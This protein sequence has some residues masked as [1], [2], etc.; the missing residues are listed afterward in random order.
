MERDFE[1]DDRATLNISEQSTIAPTAAGDARPGSAAR[2]IF[3]PA[4]LVAGRYRIVRFIAR[5]GMG[6]VYEAEDLDLRERVALKT[7]R[8][9]LV[10]E[11]RMVERFKREINLARKIAHPNVCRIFDL[12]RHP[13]AATA[14]GA[15][16]E[17]MFLTMEF[18]SGETLEARLRRAGRLSPVEALPLVRQMADALAA[19]HRAGV[20]HR[21]F[22]SANVMLVPP[23]SPDEETRVVITDFGLAQTGGG[24]SE[25]RLTS[26]TEPGW[27]VGTP[28]YIAP[29]QLEGKPTTAAADIYA[30]GVV[31]YEMTTGALPFD[32]DSPLAAALKRLHAAP[33]RP[34]THAPELAP[35]WEQV[36]LRCLEREPAERFQSATDVPRALDGDIMPAS[37]RSLE[38]QRLEVAAA[39]RRR[40]RH[41]AL[42]C[43]A[44]VALVACIAVGYNLRGA[45]WLRAATP[46]AQTPTQTQA[47]RSVALLGFKN[48]SGRADADW[49]SP[50]LSEM[51][52]TELAAGERL[53]IVPGENVARMKMELSLADADSLAADT[54]ARVRTNLGTDYVV[55]G[56]YTA[57]G[58]A[59]GW[60]VRLDL[61]LQNAATGELV[62]S[63][64]EAGGDAQLFDLI[65]RVGAR[66]RSALG[67]DALTPTEAS[68]LRASLPANA[69]A[70]RLYAE[71]R[72]RLNV[73][74]ALT[75][76]DLLAR[77]VVADPNYPLAHSALASAW[78]ALGYDERARAAAQRAYDLSGSLS[79]EERLAVE[80][81]Y[82][83]ALH[84]SD[85]AIEIYRTLFDFF[86]DTIEYGL[87]LVAVQARAG[88]AQAALATVARLRQ[89]PVPTADDPR[90]DMAESLV[91]DSLA[92]YKQEQATA[93]A[94]AIKGAQRGAWLVVAE[95]RYYEGWANWN[96]GRNEQALAAYE[97]AR[98][99][100]DAAGQRKGVADILNA[101]ASLRWGQ[102]DL[103]E[104]RRLYEE[105]L[106][107]K[108]EIGQQAGI[109]VILNNLGNVLK[110]EGDLTNARRNYEAALAAYREVGNKLQFPSTLLN[111]AEVL[112]GQGDLAGAQKMYEE[113]MTYSREFGRK[114]TLA[115]ALTELSD[116]L[117][118]RGDLP[119]A[120]KSCADG[121]AVARETGQKRGIA[122]GLHRLANLLRAQGDLTAAR[123][124]YEESL[125]LRN[126]LGEASNA[127]ESRLALAE[128]ALDENRPADAE[129]LA[130][131]AVETFT[132]QRAHE[133]EAAAT[134]VLARALAATGQTEA[135]RQAARQAAELP[136]TSEHLVDRLSV[137]IAVARAQAATGHAPEATQTLQSVLT[138]ATRL[139]FVSL[140][141]EAR[142]ALLEAK[143]Q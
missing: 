82:R 129:Q 42:V 125:A 121:L 79:R 100:Y 74:D 112:K 83:E 26:L 56:S 131:A 72:A 127:A 103:D 133:E 17:I 111:L 92:D 36:I 5:G 48:L 33:S 43:V 126:E 6:E 120:Q 95:A 21:D 106:A 105:A 16:R 114:N 10:A 107:I 135:A 75:A 110:D 134:A 9:E 140:Q 119:A 76:R 99:L 115:I 132:Q 41:L 73:F 61:R 50:A 124:A 89:L 54:L 139:G 60:Q 137:A 84:E 31:L 57:L 118:L 2:A 85:K 18:L 53:R 45:R 13:L 46:D 70:A 49:L 8:A 81:S 19:A 122:Y 68:V 138:Q 11:T 71:G 109:A 28:D 96:L 20:V 1:G 69:E 32:G 104:A 116:V 67:A 24:S 27:L 141:L 123:K 86:P 59:A 25:S 66:L 97:D 117:L 38:Q 142:R 91:A 108:R 52:A 44:L 58:A 128:L 12:G 94:A 90:I 23:H 7:I 55:L 3:A 78:T 87:R 30:L 29:E 77:A 14:P 98:R 101:V 34:R 130:R 93:A 15:P 136:S 64:A 62:A 80:G 143:K 63:V 65:A 22:K 4:Q 47:R 51:L 39:R 40:Q 102:G 37:A 35:L 113:S 88:E